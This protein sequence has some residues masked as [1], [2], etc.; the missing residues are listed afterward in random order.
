M[1]HYIHLL[2]A[3]ELPY[4][5]T[6]IHVHVYIFY[7]AARFFTS[8][9]STNVPN[10]YVY[11]SNSPLVVKDPNGEIAPFIVIAGLGALK[12]IGAY[13]I[14]THPSDYTAGG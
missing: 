9:F 2:S 8:G 14:S 6:Y 7:L 11:A 4:H 1:S 13:L 5:T 10:Q 12:G 3:A